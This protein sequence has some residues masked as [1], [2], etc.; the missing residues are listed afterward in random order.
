ML[1]NCLTHQNV[2]SKFKQILRSCDFCLNCVTHQNIYC[3]TIKLGKLLGSVS[4][5]QKY[6]WQQSSLQWN[7]MAVSQKSKEMLIIIC[8]H[9]HHYSILNLKFLQT[10][11]VF[12]LI[13]KW[14]LLSYICIFQAFN[15]N[16]LP[17]QF[18]CRPRQCVEISIL[19]LQEWW[20]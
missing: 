5:H 1:W 10:L 8:P 19:V 9:C 7:E 4:W 18:C 11:I 13:L 2:Y 17:F 12:S 16:W 6:K 14:F 15:F 3:V 20:R